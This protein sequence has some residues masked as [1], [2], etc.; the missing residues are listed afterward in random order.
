MDALVEAADLSSLCGEAGSDDSNM[1]E[2]HRVMASNP[3]S[4]YWQNPRDLSSPEESCE[5]EI[6]RSVAKQDPGS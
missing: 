2:L 4:H 3:N 1:W 5:V 6:L